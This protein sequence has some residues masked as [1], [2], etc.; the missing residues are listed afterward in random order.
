MCVELY[1]VPAEPGRVSA[2]RLSE[3]SGLV[4]AKSSR[5]VTGALH[6]SRDKGCGCSLL[7]DG[8][9]WN[10]PT[11][12]LVP[13]A[14]D[15]M[16]RALSLLHK[17]AKGFTFQAIWIGDQAESESHVSLKEL[18]RDVRQNRVRN[19]HVYAIGMS[20]RGRR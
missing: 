18:L 5:P 11:G 13:E 17:E 1:A 19:K 8:A 3:V 4:V 12:D 7:G 6:F 16:A 2:D 15:G 10:E 20:G 9:D 14:L